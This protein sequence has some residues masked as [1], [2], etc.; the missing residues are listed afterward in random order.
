MGLFD[1]IGSA[2]KSVQHVG[3]KFLHGVGNIGSKVANIG[4]NILNFAGGL[5]F[6]G[7][8]IK[9][10]PLY[11]LAQTVTSGIKAG[12]KLATG[13]GD[14]LERGTRPSKG[15]FHDLYR[16]AMTGKRAFTSVRSFGN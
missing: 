2:M 3:S 13:A 1:V 5:P 7:G 8:A 12:S 4:Q 10:S 11:G 15:E 16:D 9:A 6:I 14:I